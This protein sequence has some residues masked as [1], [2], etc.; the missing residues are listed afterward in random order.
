M[1]THRNS[2]ALF[3]AWKDDHGGDEGWRSM[4]CEPTPFEG[5]RSSGS[6]KDAP[7][8]GP[9]ICVCGE[10]VPRGAPVSVSFSALDRS[11]PTAG[12]ITY[13]GEQFWAAEIRGDYPLATIIGANKRQL[14]DLRRFADRPDGPGWFRFERVQRRIR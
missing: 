13:V 8:G 1:P 4:S 14:F 5:R 11:Q 12:N 3:E 9:W 6:H 10:R 7:F 2:G